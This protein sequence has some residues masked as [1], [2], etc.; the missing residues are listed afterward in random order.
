MS[1]RCCGC[2]IMMAAL[3]IAGC[4]GEAEEDHLEHHIPPHKPA[5]LI[6]A[7]EQLEHRIP[8]VCGQDASPSD[9]DQQELIDIVLWIP[10]LAADS[11]LRKADWETAA[12]VSAQMQKTL[13]SSLAPSVK[14]SD[15]QTAQKQLTPLIHDLKALLPRVSV[16]PHRQPGTSTE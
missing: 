15:R 5:N 13:L 16:D 6:E 3:L 10:E 14:Q 1:Y 11:D 4:S 8:L 2:L 7:V 12:A 9:T